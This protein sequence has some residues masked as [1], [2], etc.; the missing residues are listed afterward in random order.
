[1][2]GKPAARDCWHPQYPAFREQFGEDPAR[3]LY[4]DVSERPLIDGMTNPERIRAWLE[5][6]TDRADPRRPV[7]AALNERLTAVREGGR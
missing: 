6:E 4:H 7:V 5:V 3:F 2:T 1:M